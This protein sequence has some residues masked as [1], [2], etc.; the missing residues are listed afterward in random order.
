MQRHHHAMPFLA[1]AAG[2]ASFSVMDALMKSA[3]LSL[4]AYNA[5]LWRSLVGIVLIAPLWKLKG[6]HWPKGAIMRLHAQ[7]GLN[8]A[9]MATSFFW[10]LKYLP[11]AEGMAI[12]F[13]APLIALYLAAALLGETIGRTALL[14][15]AL[16]LA[17]VLVSAAARLG[18]GEYDPK[19]AWGIAAILFSALTYAWNLILQRR[20][21]QLASPL[22]VAMFQAFFTSLFLL[23]AAPWLATVPQGSAWAEIGG[24]SVLAAISLM[25]ISWGYGREETQVLLPLEYSAFIWAALLGWLVFGEG[26]TAPTVAGAVLIVAGCLLAAPRKHIEQTAL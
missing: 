8:S 23:L 16:G 13:I 22:E 3:S 10:G 25:L 19:V 26:L 14:A 11:L 21:A 7:R 12:S 1:V 15:S 4:G 18:R 2:I 9:V 17:G 6:G 20:Q 5:M 24:S